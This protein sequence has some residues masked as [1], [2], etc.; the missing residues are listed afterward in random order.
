MTNQSGLPAART[1]VL[2]SLV[3]LLAAWLLLVARH[4][5]SNA[6]ASFTQRD[7]LRIL[8]AA[9]AR[10]GG[11][12]HAAAGD[13][14][15]RAQPLAG[16]QPEPPTLEQLLAA[17]V[18][19][20]SGSRASLTEQLVDALSH[21]SG[22]AAVQAAIDAV[23]ARRQQVAQLRAQLRRAAA[24]LDGSGGGDGRLTAAD[25]EGEE[26]GSGDGITLPATSTVHCTLDVDGTDRCEVTNL[27]VD[28]AGPHA[29]GLHPIFSLIAPP[30]E[31]A[32]AAAMRANGSARGETQRLVPGEPAPLP[33]ASPP[34]RP[35]ADLVRRLHA[36]S[37]KFD[38]IF[39]DVISPYFPYEERLLPLHFGGDVRLIPPA[40]ALTAA[41]A[42]GEFNGTVTWV[43]SAYVATAM[44]GEHMWGCSSSV[45][46]PLI[47]AT[48]A[49]AS[50]EPRR[51]LPPLDHLIITAHDGGTHYYWDYESMWA[52]A[53]EA[54]GPGVW[55]RAFLNASLSWIRGGATP[56][57]GKSAA[58][59]ADATYS[60][61]EAIAR[62]LDR[63]GGSA[64]SQE[65]CAA[66]AA[67]RLPYEAFSLVRQQPSEGRGTRVTWNFRDLPPQP[68]LTPA[69]CGVKG[70]PAAVPTDARRMCVRRAVVLGRKPLLLGGDA[71][72]AAF[73]VFA[74][75][76]L[77]VR[78][79]HAGGGTLFA[80][81][82]R[83]LIVDRGRRPDGRVAPR[84]FANRDG[85]T[86]LLD[87]YGIPYDILED[88]DAVKLDFASQARAWGS[89]GLII[90]GHGAGEVNLVFAPARAVVIE[91]SPYGL[92]CNMYT[93]LAGAMGLQS[94]PIQSR[95]KGPGLN[96]SYVTRNKD[97]A[98]LKA[99]VEY[100][101]SMS[102]PEQ[103]G[104]GACVVEYK[105]GA[106]VTPL[107]EFEHA[108]THAL[109][110]LGRRTYANN[111]ALDL[112]EGVPD[113]GP[114]EERWRPGL[115]EEARAAGLQRVCAAAAAGATAGKARHRP[116]AGAW[117]AAAQTAVGDAD[118]SAAFIA[119]GGRVVAAEGR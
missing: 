73:R 85:M 39:M 106:I 74:S 80:R 81:P 67:L 56:I 60:A 115:Q 41:H 28:L 90:T 57:V 116:A 15:L 2:G 86:A 37:H 87:K 102:L 117:T 71:D 105:V 77:G 53:A 70:S 101:E 33:L 9:S 21:V 3:T 59:R 26:E 100:C 38:P 50:A 30:R 79:S 18:A 32:V 45:M 109:E 42:R 51:R 22:A 118:E 64:P 43:D 35:G 49:N 98:Q 114:G 13:E 23:V 54:T 119:A 16:P 46:F 103:Q 97:D 84:G 111:S 76:A 78:A 88:A 61:L 89:H 52:L 31:V 95:L 68:E 25:E 1:I 72:T 83:A 4:V 69:G 112:L 27:C 58:G 8:A 29:D 36:A 96:Y 48:W 110:L 34:Q 11:H 92:W 20:N 91:I 7:K 12:K 93:K 14:G 5:G 113:G 6:D 17:A 99:K 66:A 10:H 94:I 62:A 19:A 63:D 104:V 55:C 75:S 47:S 108:L 44:L 65:R 24:H 82:L 40:A 107:L